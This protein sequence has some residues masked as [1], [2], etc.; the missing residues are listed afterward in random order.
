ME[1]KEALALK[2][3]TYDTGRPC[4]NGHLTY[5]YTSTGSCAMC[6]N[7]ENKNTKSETFLERATRI[8]LSA[9]STYNDGLK[10]LTAIYEESM[11]IAKELREKSQHI[12]LEEQSKSIND[13]SKLEAHKAQQARKA[14]IKRMIKRN[15]FIYTDDVFSVKE[16]LLDKA[17]EIE[18]NLT[19]DDINYK[20][21]VQG[22][23]L[24]QIR[25]FPE[26][27]KEIIEVTNRIYNERNLP[28]VPRVKPQSQH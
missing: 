28:P 22:N 2:L 16:F 19:M 3:K 18:P 10:R 9:L 26:H 6:V 27:E 14:A 11:S 21:K 25:C 5:R 8:E 17:R 12:L 7:G 4:I 15:V 1:R 23:V 20:Y 24:H 13:K